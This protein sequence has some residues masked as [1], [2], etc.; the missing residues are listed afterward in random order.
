MSF[1]DD[2]L[3]IVYTKFIQDFLDNSVDTTIL[4]YFQILLSW[5][6]YG[7][8][9]LNTFFYIHKRCDKNMNQIQQFVKSVTM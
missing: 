3:I 9:E 2:S 1:V 7:D 4:S 5:A 8:C 6:K